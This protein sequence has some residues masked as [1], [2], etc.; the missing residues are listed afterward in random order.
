MSKSICRFH[1][2]NQNG[3][4]NFPGKARRAFR[5]RIPLTTHDGIAFPRHAVAY[6]SKVTGGFP[7]AARSDAGRPPD[8]ARPE[9]GGY[10]ILRAASMS[11]VA[12]AP[13]IEARPG[14]PPGRD[15]ISSPSNWRRWNPTGRFPTRCCSGP[16]RFRSD[17]NCCSGSSC[18]SDSNC[19]CS[20]RCCSGLSRS[21]PNCRQGCFRTGP[22]APGASCRRRSP[23]SCPT[24]AAAFCRRR[25]HSDRGPARNGNARRGR[26]RLP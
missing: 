8:G 4:L 11:A 20:I 21:C 15:R 7:S 2:C 12:Q 14:S 26:R 10:A 23:A 24:E 6:L 5:Y 13:L 22:T 3:N 25:S 1:A 17:R 19:S 16:S 9:Y 18:H